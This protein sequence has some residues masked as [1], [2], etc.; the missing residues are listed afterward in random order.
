MG[1][2]GGCHP[3]GRKFMQGTMECSKLEKELKAGP[4][5]REQLLI[6]TRTCCLTNTLLE[7][8][9]P[10]VA[11]ELGSLFAKEGLLTALV[12]KALPPEFEHIRGMRDVIECRFFANPAPPPSRGVRDEMNVGLETWA[13]F[14]CPVAGVEMNGRYPFVVLRRP[15]GGAAGED[16][17]VNVLSEKA[18]KQVGLDALQAEYGP[19]TEADVIKLVPTDVERARM[20]ANLDTARAAERAA[21]FDAKAAKKA[22]K[23]K[24]EDTGD[25]PDPSGGATGGAEEPAGDK[26]ERRAAKKAA[27]AAKAAKALGAGVKKASVSEARAAALTG[28]VQAE[29]ATALAAAQAQNPTLKALFHGTGSQK[30]ESAQYQFICQAGKK[31]GGS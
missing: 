20:V 18:L 22:S 11:D 30:P 10:I 15:G 8:D 28:A 24:A 25:G 9:S 23:R 14:S 17:R 21:K 31:M 12:E 5:K 27:K 3:N 7:A 19:V 16:T 2:D 4:D 6:R 1:G 29:A 13:P 26:E